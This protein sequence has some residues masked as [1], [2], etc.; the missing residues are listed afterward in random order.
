MRLFGFRNFFCFSIPQKKSVVNNELTT[1]FVRNGME[2]QRK[3]TT[4]NQDKDWVTRGHGGEPVSADTPHSRV[5][6]IAC[7]PVGPSMP[8]PHMQIGTITVLFMK[9]I[10]KLK[11]SLPKISTL[12]DICACRA[13]EHSHLC[14]QKTEPTICIQ[15]GNAHFFFFQSTYT[16]IAVACHFRNRV[17]C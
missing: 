10:F 3:H 17:I 2:L 16:K 12:H 9:H 6:D 13:S 15:Y 5:Q 8:Q 11:E 4:A 1:H 7:L 14:P